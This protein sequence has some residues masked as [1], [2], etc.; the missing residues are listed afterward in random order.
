[1]IPVKNEAELE[2]MRVSGRLAAEVLREVCS[3]VAPVVSTSSTTARCR[4]L[5]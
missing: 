2:A 1:M 5:T 3:A 4:P